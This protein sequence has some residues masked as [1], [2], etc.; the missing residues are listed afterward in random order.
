MVAC[1]IKCGGVVNQSIVYD[2]SKMV[3]ILEIK[4]VRPNLKISSVSFVNK[5][6][7]EYEY[8]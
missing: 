5:C 8:S 1:R 7:R 3:G 4:F 2:T 6:W